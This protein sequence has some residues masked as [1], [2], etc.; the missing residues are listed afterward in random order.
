MIAPSTEDM[1]REEGPTEAEP[2]KSWLSECGED[3]STKRGGTAAAIQHHYDVSDA[4]YA[5]WLDPTLT[6]SCAL[7]QDGDDADDLA[8]AQLRKLDY[9]LACAGA[10]RARRILDIGCGWGS[11]LERAL[12]QPHIETATG[13]TLSATQFA[14]IRARAMR[15]WNYGSR[16]GSITF[17][18]TNTMRSF[19]SAH[20]S[21]LPARRTVRR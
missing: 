19:R 1:S 11:L 7:W 6:Y 17:R 3:G 2:M 20:S 16:V 8:A 10:P 15:G 5:L 18:P 13:L 4:F 9:H 12:M 21:I 14:H